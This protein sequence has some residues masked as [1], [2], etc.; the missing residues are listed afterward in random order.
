MTIDKRLEE[1]VSVQ[2]CWKDKRYLFR[3]T[4]L[5]SDAYQCRYQ[6]PEKVEMYGRTR[7]Q[8]F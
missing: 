2:E 7:I 8:V 4:C 3:N 6:G 5:M 1:P